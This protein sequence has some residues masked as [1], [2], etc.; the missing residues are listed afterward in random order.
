MRRTIQK[1]ISLVVVICLSSMLFVQE[2]L[3]APTVKILVNPNQKDVSAGSDPIALTAQAAGS[4]LKYRWTLNGPGKI[5]NTNLPAVFYTVPATISGSSAQAV[6]TVTVTDE[7]GQES[8]ESIT[9]NIL[10]EKKPEPVIARK[11]GM[12]TMTKVGLGLGGTALLVGGIALAT[13]GGDDGNSEPF[14]GTFRGDLRS[15]VSTSGS[16][17]TFQYTLNLTQSG[18]TISGNVVK[19][20]TLPGC[21]TNN[22]TVAVIG[23]VINQTTANISWGSGEGT[24][25][26]T[27]G[28]GTWWSSVSSD[29]GQA[30]L[31]NNNKTLR[32]AGGAEYTRAKLISLDGKTTSESQESPSGDFMRE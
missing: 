10:P 30:T 20:S 17:Y 23:S 19:A 3:A 18:N 13:G 26:C 28:T 1:F 8:T 14:T 32:F 7:Q 6:I 29:S 25:Q 27:Q 22:V 5:D 4:N 11:Q 31:I 15:G 2:G 21:C 12:S 24:C 16:S 9:L